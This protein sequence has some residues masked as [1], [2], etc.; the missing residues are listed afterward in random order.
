LMKVSAAG[1]EPADLKLPRSNDVG[2]ANRFAAMSPQMLPGGE[3]VIYS[4]AESAFFSDVSVSVFSLQTGQSQVLIS[5][6]ADARYVKATGQLA[7]AKAGTRMAVPFDVGSLRLTGGQV[8]VVDSVLQALNGRTNLYRTGAAQFAFSDTGVLAYVAG[9]IYRDRTNHLLLVD[10]DRANSQPEILT[11]P[12]KG[13]NAPR[14][15]PDGRR[16]VVSSGGTVSGVWVYDFERG[17]LRQLLFKGR[18]NFA[19]WTPN[20]D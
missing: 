3:S 16:V 17:D 1:G 5:D 4:E 6:A 8:G 9:G 12:P 15:S 11:A 2:G 18:A 10:L 14:F 7:F 20:G 13:Y 19:L